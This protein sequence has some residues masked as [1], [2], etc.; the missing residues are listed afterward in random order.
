MPGMNSGLNPADPTLVAAFRSALLH[1]GLIAAA[2][3]L[4]LWL[5][6]GA[7]RNW[8]RP[9]AAVHAPRAAELVGP[10]GAA[11]RLRAA[12]GVRRHLAGPAADARRLAVPGHRADRAELAA[13]GPGPG[14][15]WRDHLVQSPDHGCRGL[16]VDPGRHRPVAAG[17]RPG[18]V[19]PR[20]RAGQRGVGADGVDLG[21]V[22]RRD[23]RP[24]P[25]LADRRAR[26]GAALLRGGRADRAAGAR[27]ADG[28]HRAAAAGR[29][30]PVLHRHGGAAG[31][32]GSRL[33]AG[34]VRQ[35]VRHGDQHG[36]DLSAACFVGAGLRVRLLRHR[37]RLRRE[38]V[39]G[40]RAGD[41]RRGAAHRAA[42]AGPRRGAGCGRCVPR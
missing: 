35:P 11:D 31:V 23:L 41:D 38:P 28:P 7:S 42:S 18:L 3:F 20:R 24:W 29:G 33:L 13:L 30:W 21:R 34:Q 15:R 32:A 19:V 40:D 26:R 5:L 25:F 16:G 27:L 2:L 4:L 1:Q 8:L 6:W 22:L 9:G 12:V 36:A 17:R 39:R 14:Q 37:A 10:P